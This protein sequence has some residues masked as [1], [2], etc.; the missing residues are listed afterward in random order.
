MAEL[1]LKS[2]FFNIWKVW[3]FEKHVWHNY[4]PLKWLDLIILEAYFI[5]HLE[6][7]DAAVGENAAVV[8]PLEI[9][10]PKRVLRLIF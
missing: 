1:V 9:K 2:D 4:N 3:V 6:I 5:E 8:V 7:F 10:F